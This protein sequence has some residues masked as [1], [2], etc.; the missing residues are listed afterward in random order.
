MGDA[1]MRDGAPLT[2]VLDK[3]TADVTD[4]DFNLRAEAV[5]DAAAEAAREARLAEEAQLEDVMLPP[6][7]DDVVRRYNVDDIA[8]RARFIPVRLT[9]KERKTLRLVS[10]ALDVSEYTDKARGHAPVCVCV[11][12]CASVCLCAPRSE[13]DGCSSRLQV[14]VLT[15]GSRAKRI[16]KQLLDVCAI[17][18]GLY[19]A[20][21]YRGGQKLV[22]D[23]EFV[24]NEEWF[25]TAFELARRYKVGVRPRARACDPTCV[26]VCV[27]VRARARVCVRVPD[28]P[29]PYTRAHAHTH[30]HT[31]AR[32]S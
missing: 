29:F 5:V 30:A 17:L 18:S 20:A 8:D 1:E 13:A 7:D 2:S 24:Q 21:D 9:L 4:S 31:H 12:V 11:C 23:R 6:P 10:A 19:V 27:C 3:D 15:Y 16:H 22:K 32:R 26:C 14:D 25:R 28:R